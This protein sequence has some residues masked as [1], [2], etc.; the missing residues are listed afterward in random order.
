MQCITTIIMPQQFACNAM[1]KIAFEKS[2]FP[3]NV[4]YSLLSTVI[5]R[6]LTLATINEVEI[7][8]K[9]P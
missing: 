7:I 1:I 6:I 8:E 9:T 4:H 2:R 3:D 5:I